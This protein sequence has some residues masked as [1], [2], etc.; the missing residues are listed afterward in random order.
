MNARPLS[1]LQL[2]RAGALTEILLRPL[3][4]LFGPSDRREVAERLERD[5]ARAATGLGR[6]QRL[7]VDGYLVRRAQLPGEAFDVP[8]PFHWSATAAA[9]V[10]GLA[11]VRSCVHEQGR[12]PV[13][14]TGLVMS[15]VAHEASGD[16]PDSLGHWLRTI[17]P[18]AR[19]A[20][21][22]T[23]VTWA[24]ALYTALDWPRLGPNPD[25][26]GADRWWDCP[27]APSVALR[28][29]AEV[30]ATVSEPATAGPA[31]AGATG[32]PERG[33]SS[34]LFVVGNGHPGSSSADELALV[35]LADVLAR[36]LAP[37]AARVVGW[38]PQSGRGLALTVG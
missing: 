36:P 30:R 7:R 23:A 2:P 11:A 24:T 17:R 29:R 3:A 20:V 33:R 6:R 12:S 27:S 1:L 8:G 4:P 16:A 38:W 14:A 10:I 32:P 37:P 35:A 28:S 34:V 9:R 13:E 5:L 26:G 21:R 19:A 31:D 15:R 25:V 22:A 18:G